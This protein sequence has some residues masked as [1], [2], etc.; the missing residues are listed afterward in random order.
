M[1]GRDYARGLMSFDIPSSHIPSS[2]A[3]R[4]AYYRIT[5]ML[6]MCF[7]A[8]TDHTEGELLAQS[9]NLSG[10]GLASW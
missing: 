5:V 10:G 2:F 8:E 1:P 7:Q 9:V 3:D 4:R 6:P